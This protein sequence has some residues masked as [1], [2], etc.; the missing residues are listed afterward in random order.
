MKQSDKGVL[1][2]EMTKCFMSLAQYAARTSRWLCLFIPILLLV[3]LPTWSQMN[4]IWIQA[5]KGPSRAISGDDGLLH[6]V[7]IDSNNYISIDVGQPANGYFPD[8][9][10][11][12]S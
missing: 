7:F 5:A 3:A 10:T 9:G 8:S 2:K 1:M 4:L 11:P 12:S 6:R